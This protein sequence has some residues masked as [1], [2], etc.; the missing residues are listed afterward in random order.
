MKTFKRTPLA[1]AIAALMASPFA[2]AGQQSRSDVDV[3]VDKEWETDVDIEVEKDLNVDKDVEI[4]AR[5]LG[6]GLVFS[7]AFSQ[8]YIESNQVGIGNQT[9]EFRMQDNNARVN[10]S[11][12]GASGNV[13]I[14]VTSGDNNQQANDAALAL[15][16][17]NFVFASS[18]VDSLQTNTGQYVDNFDVS[19]NASVN[20]SLNG[21][22]GNL[23]LNVSAGT[24]N[25]QHNALA[26]SVN[27]SFGTYAE[28]DVV[29]MQHSQGNV[30]DNVGRMTEEVVVVPVSLALNADGTYSGQSDQIGD[31][32]LDTWDGSLPHPGGNSTGHIDLDDQVQGAQDLNDD[33]GALAFNEAGDIVLSGTVSGAIPVVVAM[34]DPHVNNATLGGSLNNA[35]GNVGVNISA[36]T[37]NQQRNALAISAATG[38]TPGEGPGPGEIPVVLAQ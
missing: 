1:L 31:L 16:D 11:G 17:A 23:G 9:P 14:N 29:G 22:S 15:A 33:G 3:D 28:A 38:G 34:P 7:D 18:E 12:S 5:V 10:G 21:V 30:T 32:Y 20:N 35:S 19:N 27:T 36:G 26:A 8:A 2:L 24:N 37:G 6:F 13:G 25:Q 4:D